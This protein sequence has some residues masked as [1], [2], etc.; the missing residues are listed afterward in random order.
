MGLTYPKIN[1]PEGLVFREQFTTNTYVADNGLTLTDVTIGAGNAVFNGTTSIA[2]TGK[3][4]IGVGDISVEILLDLTGYGEANTGYLVSN[5]Q[6]VIVTN[7]TNDTLNVTSNFFGNSANAATDA[8]KAGNTYHIV[9]TRVAAGDTTIYI[10][11]MVSGTP[12]S[13]GTPVAGTTNM[14]IGNRSNGTRTADGTMY[15][16]NV[17]DRVLTAAEVSDRLT[18]QTFKEPIPEFSEIWLPLKSHYYDTGTSKEVTT[19]LGNINSDQVR[20]GDGSTTTTYPTLLE[21]NGVYMDTTDSIRIPQVLSTY[22]TESYT[23]CALIKPIG[24][25]A[26]DYLFTLKTAGSL[27]ISTYLN[28]TTNT[29]VF[30]AN[31]G[32]AAGQVDVTNMGPAAGL[33]HIACVIEY[34]GASDYD[35]F[36]YKDGILVGSDLAATGF[37]A[38]E[39]NVGFTIGCNEGFVNSWAGN[40]FLPIFT[41][42]ALTPTQI[43]WLKEYSYNSLN[44]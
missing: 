14:I 18:Q 33:Y 32:A 30:F 8:I 27:G 37:T 3:E 6:F 38:S 25:V 41:R 43:K 42:Q 35:L 11:G 7:D 21:N 4:Y 5:D 13:S 9:V 23:F 40:I 20:W 16:F 2:D 17:Y 10:N 22:A 1:P 24:N 28:S 26:N 34:K 29:M 39:G 12:A 44:I 36:V 19:N 15:E 31:S